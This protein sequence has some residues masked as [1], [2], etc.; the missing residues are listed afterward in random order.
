M[1]L[2]YTLYTKIYTQPLAVR[3]RASLTCAAHRELAVPDHRPRALPIAGIR[4]PGRK[5]MSFQGRGFVK[6]LPILMAATAL[7]ATPFA[8]GSVALAHFR[9]AR[10]WARPPNSTR[11]WDWSGLV[12]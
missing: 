1:L 9:I 3:S 12:R 11:R 5:W 2:A 8:F 6:Y 4:S 7:A 10:R